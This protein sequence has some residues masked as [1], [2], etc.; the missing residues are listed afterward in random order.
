MAF[1][2]VLAFTSVASA[3]GVRLHNQDAKTY[4]LYVKH[5]GS[6]VNTSIGPHTITN[7]CSDSCTIRL[8]DTGTSIMAGPGDTIRIKDGRLYRKP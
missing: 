7:I 6:A 4:Q 1:L 2:L 5:R 3:A 8:K